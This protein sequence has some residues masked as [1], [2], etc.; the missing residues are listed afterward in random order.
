MG[1]PRHNGVQ[2]APIRNLVNSAGKGHAVPQD[3]GRLPP[4]HA[5]DAAGFVRLAGAARAQGPHAL[6]RGR[7]AGSAMGRQ[8]RRQFRAEKRRRSGRC[9]LCPR[10][11]LPRRQDGR[12]SAS[13]R[14]AKRTSAARPT[15]ICGSRTWIATASTPRSSTASSAPPRASTTAKP[16]TRCCASTMTGSRISAATI[17]SADRPCLSALWR[18]RGGGRGDPPGRQDGHQGARAIVLLGHGADVAS[19]MGAG[20]EGGRGRAIAVP[21]PH[22]PDHFAAGARRCFRPSPAGRDV[23]RGVGIPDGPDQHHR[24]VDRRRRA[25]TLSADRVSFGESGIGWIPTRST[26]WISSSRIA[27]AI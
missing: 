16:P 8:E 7:A 10:P 26:A 21:F 15:R 27:S 22:L 24:G 23:Y 4:R 19:G 11:E 12:D 18:Y 6:C 14:T 20:V 9:A 17:L 13:S 3:F 1:N 5:V 25:G 2:S